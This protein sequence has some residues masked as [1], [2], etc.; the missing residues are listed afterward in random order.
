MMKVVSDLH[1]HSRFARACSKNTDIPLL[2]KYAKIKGLN[3]LGTG[4]VQHPSWLKELKS[5]LSERD[6]LAFTK[7]DFPFVLQTELSLIYTQ[8]NKGRRV[9][10][11]ILL[12]SFSAVDQLSDYLLKRGR[13]DYDG[14]PI[15]KIPLP[16]LVENLRSIDE[17][18]EIIPAHA[19][20]PWF[21]IFGSKTGFDS[22][23]DAFL[24]QTKHIH[25]IETGLSSDP[26]MNWRLKELDNINLVSFSDAH[27]YWPWRIGREA[28][29]FQL[30]DLNYDNLIKAIRSGNGLSETVEFFPEEGKY[31]FDGHRNCNVCFSPEESKRH[32]L[33]CPVCKKPLTL[34][35]E[36]RV[37]QLANRD[38]GITP[39]NAK[40]FKSL[41]PLMELISAS[42]RSSVSSQKNW[43]I[44]NDLIKEFKN[45]FDILLQTP[46]EDIKK[47]ADDKLADFILRNRS[48]RIEFLP[49][50]DG[51]YG[52]P[53]LNGEE[54]K[55]KENIISRLS[56]QKS[57]GE[58]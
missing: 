14:R 2:E 21:G 8:D 37:E 16:E 5:V 43:K 39:G 45:E 13:I 30:K 6:G 15:F 11:V 40:P 4:D 33:I 12:P 53:L 22:L 49:G 31:H 58:F 48:Q 51:E 10:V 24:D 44:F 3:L 56:S 23:K 42:T 29:I 27:S 18:I 25:A 34:G 26:P 46:I 20:T 9:H 17:R 19:W 55:N 35:V 7:T 1:I 47:I 36:Y 32:N 38:K 52:T 57:L 54:K 41:I 50:Y 28:T